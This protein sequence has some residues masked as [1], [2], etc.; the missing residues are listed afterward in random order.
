M[1]DV[2]QEEPVTTGVAVTFSQA[3]QEKK[4]HS[5][6]TSLFRKT[7]LSTTDTLGLLEIVLEEDSQAQKWLKVTVMDRK[8]GLN[9]TTVFVFSPC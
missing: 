7:I 2:L 9:Y 6:N 4:N 3:D 1:A 5:E 8:S